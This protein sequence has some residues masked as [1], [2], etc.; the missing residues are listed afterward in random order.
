M[1][2]TDLFKKISQICFLVILGV[3]TQSVLARD[4]ISSMNDA[5]STLESSCHDIDFHS[6]QEK[7]DVESKLKSKNSNSFSEEELKSV[8]TMILNSNSN[9]SEE[10]RSSLDSVAQYLAS[11][12][13]QYKVTGIAF[14]VDPNVALIWDNQNPNFAVTYKNNEGKMRSRRFQASI[15]SVGLKIGF[16][17]NLNIIFL[18][19]DLNYENTGQVLNLG[20][21]VDIN[22]ATPLS[23]I[24]VGLF[25]PFSLFL[26]CAPILNAPG[27][28]I[29]L[30]LDFGIAKGVS[31]V[32]DGTLTP[33][34]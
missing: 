8:I 27:N 14:A 5:V 12:I 15:N 17:L 26:T 32:T 10:T 19:G 25:L 30:G 33:E 22:L 16:S 31:M 24:G 11:S 9:I 2:Q 13:S 23:L 18:T 34:K 4:Q 1:I 20:T 28:F 7:K 6:Y 21:G 29:M 3:Q